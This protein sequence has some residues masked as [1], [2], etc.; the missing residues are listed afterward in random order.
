MTQE[1][2]INELLA[3]L[4]AEIVEKIKAETITEDE[5]KE[6]VLPLAEK[7]ADKIQDAVTPLNDEQLEAVNGGFDFIN[8]VKCLGVSV[9][10]G[11]KT[12]SKCMDNR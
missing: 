1:E 3:K 2:I 8:F 11:R 6:Y 4:P 10:Q 9:V 12:Y 5:L 7:Y